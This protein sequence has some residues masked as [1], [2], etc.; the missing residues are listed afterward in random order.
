MAF[1]PYYY[2]HKS[3]CFNCKKTYTSYKVRP[4]RTKVIDQDTDFMPICDGLNPLL[5]EVNV[6]PN[7]G[8][9]Y[10]KS[11]TRVYSPFIQIVQE[12]YINKLDKAPNL[13]GERTI[14]DAITS[15]KLAYLVANSAMEEAIVL[16]NFSLKIAW[17]YR[18]KGD[19]ENEKR[20]LKSTQS[21]F[22]NAFSTAKDGDDKI[23][24]LMAEIDLRL[25][26]IPEAKKRF[27]KIIAGRKTSEKFRKIA[28]KR[29]EDYIY[30]FDKKPSESDKI[31]VEEN[32]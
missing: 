4:N 26:D 11:M 21:F 22:M 14:D 24:Y 29:W 13:C 30:D 6:C 9:A 32:I 17:L 15:Y 18:L 16:G 5:Y 2:E 3:E 7:C 31:T 27:S 23:Q 28:K 19:V 10:H 20:Y 1:N 25:G 8:Y 12:L